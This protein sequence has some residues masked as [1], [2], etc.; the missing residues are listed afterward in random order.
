MHFATRS[1]R[2]QIL[3]WLIWAIACLVFTVMPEPAIVNDDVLGGRLTLTGIVTHNPR[4]GPLFPW[5][6]RLRWRKWAWRQYHHLRRAHRRAQWMARLTRLTLRG[7]LTLAQLVDL[8][9]RSQLRWHLGALPVLYALLEVLQVREII[10]RYCPT[11]AE[12]DHGAVAVVLILNRLTVP[13]PL[14]QVADW[15]AQTVLVYTLGVPAEKFNDDRLARTLDAVSQ[16][17]REIW[18]DIVHQALVQAEVD[19]SLIFYDLT[20]FVV[21]GA[22]AGSQHADFGFAHNTPMNKR[23][24]KAGL[25]VSADGNMPAEYSLWSGRVA[26]L[27]TVQENMERLSRLLKQR[28]WPLDEVLIIGDRANLNDELAFAYDDH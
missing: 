23:K 5:L 13:C 22:Y 21:H 10:N 24:F 25:N 14:Y 3:V 18:Q 26:D 11:V 28:G 6:S 27:S 4:H 12:V 8:L 7:A 2:T 20:A 15:L 9:I 16:H 19:L 1:R 17:T